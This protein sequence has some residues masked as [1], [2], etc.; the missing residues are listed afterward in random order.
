MLHLVILTCIC[1]AHAS[2]YSV[3]PG[4]THLHLVILACIC[5]A[6]AS[7]HSVEPGSTV[8]YLVMLVRSLC[9]YQYSLRR[10]QFDNT[11]PR[12]VWCAYLHVHMHCAAQNIA[13]VALSSRVRHG[14]H[15]TD[16]PL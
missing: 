13:G 16:A 2:L 11:A 7:T 10:T 9:T 5:C 14:V 15:W 4:S 1:S 12:N 8:V 3:E 6:N